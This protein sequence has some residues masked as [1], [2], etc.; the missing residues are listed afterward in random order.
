M[1]LSKV[2][3]IDP[4]I[5]SVSIRYAA[6]VTGNA[7]V[8][9][10]LA[11]GYTDGRIP[12]ANLDV[13]GNAYISGTTTLATQ[14]VTSRLFIGD[15]TT[16]IPVSEGQQNWTQSHETSNRGGISLFST[17]NSTG[18]TELVQAKGRSGA[19]GSFTIV[20][21]DDTLGTLSWCGD[22]GTNMN[23]V[24]ARITAAVD[25][26]P[27]ENDMP[28]RLTFQ[29]TADGATSPTERA[30]ITSA[31]LVGIGTTAPHTNQK[32]HIYG[33]DSGAAGST[34]LGMTIENSGDSQLQ[35]LN[36]E[37][38]GY[39]SRI[40]FGSVTNARDG[41]IAYT[42]S[43]KYMAFHA[44]NA[45]KLRLNSTGLGIGTTSPATALDVN[46]TILASS[47]TYATAQGSITLDF[48]A[49]QNFVLTFIADVTFANPS[50]EQVGQAGIFV[51]TQG[52]SGGPHTLSLGT[53][54]ETAGSG[55]ITLSTGANDVDIIPYFVK[56]SGAIMLGAVQKDFG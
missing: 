28:G 48:S 15:M 43:A 11:V 16:S 37:S 52:A 56:A 32:I 44:A 40:N 8:T 7:S 18:G 6:N 10:S 49:T 17:H 23:S 42:Q 5:D 29:T 22:D 46:G 53:D 25:G 51:I 4:A 1:A 9:R 13:K 41:M 20:Q 12:Q 39:T 55:G 14:K 35:F 26:T 50:T 3:L 2:G 47:N 33:G 38:A 36:P 31:G 19:I 34:D 27:G 54:Y 45:E 24:G 30:R 21:D